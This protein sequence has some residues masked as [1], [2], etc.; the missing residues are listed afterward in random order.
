MR[1]R[2]HGRTDIRAAYRRSPANAAADRSANQTPGVIIIFSRLKRRLK[3]GIQ[4]RF[5]VSRVKYGIIERRFKC[6][7]KRSQKV[8]R[9]ARA[10]R[11]CESGQVAA[12]RATLA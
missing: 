12:G 6:C 2:A 8:Q 11:P 3:H 4:R 9:S 5:I 1:A 7:F 10:R